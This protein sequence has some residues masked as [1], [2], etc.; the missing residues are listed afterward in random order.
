MSVLA[1]RNIERG[2]NYFM[3]LMLPKKHLIGQN[4]R[5]MADYNVL[6]IKPPTPA[7]S[8]DS[9]RDTLFA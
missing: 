6:Y 3:F 1:L 2:F 9:K 8:Y 5:Y 7:H 4:H